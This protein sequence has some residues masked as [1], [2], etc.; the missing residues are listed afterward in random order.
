MEYGERPARSTGRLGV[1]SEGDSM[2]FPLAGTGQAWMGPIAGSH[3]AKYTRIR[4][5]TFDFGGYWRFSFRDVVSGYLAAIPM[6]LQEPS[7]SL[8]LVE[9]NQGLVG[10]AKLWLRLCSQSC[11]VSLLW[12]G[13]DGCSTEV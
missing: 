10:L 5:R 9:C 8:S 12:F 4:S 1:G 11:L 7:K 2:F 13:F 3:V 6:R